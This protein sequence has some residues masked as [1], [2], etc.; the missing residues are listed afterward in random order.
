MPNMN[1]MSI[2]GH[3]GDDPQGKY[4][5]DGKYVCNFSVAVNVRRGGNNDKAVIWVKASVWGK[6]GESASKYLQKG[7]AVY[8]SGNFDVENWTDRENN[9]RFGL[10]IM[11][12]EVVFLSGFKDSNEAASEPAGAPSNIPGD[13]DI[14]F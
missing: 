2:I 11:A 6:Q 7:S 14:P 4:L 1:K 5:Q 13:D 12:N 9:A 8:I 10:K 3:L